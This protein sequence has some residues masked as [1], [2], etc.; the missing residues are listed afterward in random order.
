MKHLNPD[1]ESTHE[2]PEYEVRKVLT[3]IQWDGTLPIDLLNICEMYGLECLFQPEET[4]KEPGSVKF[5]SPEDFYIHINTHNTDCE[6]GFSSDPNKR[7]RQRFTLAHEIGHCI[8]KSHANFH[9]QKNL[10]DENNPY[11]KEYI[12]KREAQA[13]SFAAH[14][15]I[16]KKAFLQVSREVGS[17]MIRLIETTS[18]NFDVSLKVAVQQIARLANYSCIAIV[19]DPHGMPERVPVFSDDFQETGL[20]YPKSLQV[21]TRTIAHQVLNIENLQHRGEKKFPDAATWFPDTP[22]RIAEKFSIKETSIRTG[23]YGAVTILE[24][25]EQD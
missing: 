20:F 22:D 11:S 19:F 15:L 13:N 10:T 16:P 21:P 3:S 23:K 7:R 18:E 9:L 14:L 12:K 24:V 8:Y 5:I 2:D 6:N 25:I 1:L 4:M 17:N